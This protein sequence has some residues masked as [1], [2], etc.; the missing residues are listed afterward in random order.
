[1][2]KRIAAFLLIFVLVFNFSA[3]SLHVIYSDYPV[4]RGKLASSG[5]EIKEYDGT[6][7]RKT[8]EYMHGTHGDSDEIYVIYCSSRR[9]A[10]SI[11]RYAKRMHKARLAE[12]EMEIKILEY[13]LYKDNSAGS[14]TKGEYYKEYL[15]KK[16]ALAKCKEYDFGRVANVVWYG[17]KQAIID[18]T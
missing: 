10:R 2:K 3:C 16:E 12:L 11:Y 18:A 7:G 15:E 6:Y 9:V 4:V 13:A 14:S 17:T 1:M 8:V 5:Y